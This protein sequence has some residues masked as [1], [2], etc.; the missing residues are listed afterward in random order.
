ME[1]FEKALKSV[2]VLV[3]GGRVLDYMPFLT[4]IP[5]WLPGMGLLRRLAEDKKHAYMLRE[6]PWMQAQ[7]MVV[8]MTQFS[9]LLLV[10]TCSF[11]SSTERWQMNVTNS[12]SMASAILAKISKLDP[13]AALEE[14]HIAMSATGMAYAGERNVIAS[15]RTSL[16]K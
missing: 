4:A 5:T 9:Q 16:S 8:R 6:L 10:F 15:S 7:E 12:N 13:A 11:C 14:E 2:D 1:I 3:Q